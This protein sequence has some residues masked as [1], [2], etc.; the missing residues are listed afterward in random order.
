MTVMYRKSI[1]QELGSYTN[2][3]AVGDDYELW[4]RFIMNK[5]KTANIQENLVKA[6][7]GNSMFK[8]RR[9]GLKYLR[10]E[11]AEINAVYALG[12]L[13]PWHYAFHVLVKSI[14]RLSPSCMVR[15]FYKGIR[16]TS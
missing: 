9:R 7:A 6:R 8:N 11:I 4:A 13:K 16:S 10:N 15:F 3:G 12:L 1:L 14:V 2:F 5:H